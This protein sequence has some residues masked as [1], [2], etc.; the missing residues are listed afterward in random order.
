MRFRSDIIY[1]SHTFDKYINT[2]DSSDPCIHSFELPERFSMDKICNSSGIK[3]LDICTSTELKIVNGRMGDD[4]GHGS[5]TF[6]SA[7]GQSMIDYVLMSHDLFPLINNF[8]VHD[9]YSCSAHAPIQLNIDVNYYHPIP[10]EYGIK[11][12][13]IIW[14]SEKTNEFKDVLFFQSENLNTIVNEIIDST[15][16]INQGI[17]TFADTLYTATFSVFGKIKTAKRSNFSETERKFKSPWFTEECETA[18]R[19]LKSANKANRKYR[20]RDTRDVMVEKRKNYCKV[21]RW[22]RNKFK[23]KQRNTMHN[24]AKSQP[25]KFWSEIRKM[26]GHYSD[27]S[28]I[29]A[30]DFLTHFKSLF[31]SDQNF[32]N[33]ETETHISGDI[34]VNVIEQLDCAFTRTEVLAAIQSLK[35]GKSAGVDSLSPEIFIDGGD[36]LA[37]ILCKLFNHMYD[38]GIYPDSWS[39]G[40]IVPVPKKGNLNDVNNYRGITLTSIFSKIFS[41]LLDTR[42]RKWAEDNNLLTDVQ[43]GFRKQRSTIDCVFILQS[44]INKVL[45]NKQKLY[46]AFV[47]FRKAFD[48][49]YRNGIWYKLFLSGS[50]SKMIS[51]LRKIYEKVKSCVKV[52]GSY[53]QYFD[54]YMGVKQGEPLSP[55][56]FIFFINDMSKYLYEDSADLV[57]I[58]E[59]QM[60]ILLFAD[61]AV[62]FSRSKT[63]LQILLNKMCSYCNEW[64]ITVNT[65]KTVVMVFKR[66]TRPEIAELYYDKNLLKNVSKFTYL[67]V[68]VSFNGKFF[69]TQKVLAEQ[70]MKALFSLNTLFSMVSS[71]VTENKMDLDYLMQWFY[72]Y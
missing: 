72:Q 5:F 71:A 8:I 24:L 45:N 58:N 2:V 44:I 63:G 64:G 50:S 18:R 9:F 42:L 49:V 13:K 30:D 70:G 59:I 51:M 1:D 14:D 41:I 36:I 62:I 61:D 26:K 15:I 39:R 34:P 17:D 19:E 21:K 52:N 67:G 53:T 25:K 31:S 56:L 27:Q 37:P 68:T 55:L 4:A 43:F 66:G 60:F 38:N 57:S 11:V 20:S 10:E 46:C 12:E 35:R 22:A 29:T 6:M 65:D 69:Q 23:Q 7:N 47:D 48:Q 3:L 40:I 33:E 16:D 32:Q 54:S 28:K